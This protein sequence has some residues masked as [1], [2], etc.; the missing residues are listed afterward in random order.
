MRLLSSQM[1]KRITSRQEPVYSTR[2]IEANKD[3]FI[4]E[5]SRDN[6]VICKVEVKNLAKLME[7]HS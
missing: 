1:T 7:E 4:A 6:V 2:I 5:V 3:G